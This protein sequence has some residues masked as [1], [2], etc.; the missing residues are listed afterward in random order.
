M[1]RIDH[2]P[3]GTPD[4]VET[5]APGIA[6]VSTPSHGGFFVAEELRDRVPEAVA[7]ATWNQLGRAGWFEED[8][9]AA[10]VVV[11]FPEHFEADT[12][13][14]AKIALRAA[15]RG[16]TGV[17]GHGERLRA[18]AALGLAEPVSAAREAAR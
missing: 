11:C 10:Y 9:D 14:R 1:R 13:E 5:L 4:H 6:F 2:S 3:W 7:N 16:L 8:H 15:G 18:L 17:R 12:V